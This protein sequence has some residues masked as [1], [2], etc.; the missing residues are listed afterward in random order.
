MSTKTVESKPIALREREAADAIGVAV[1]TLRN[2]RYMTPIKG[3]RPSRIGR[4]V[5]Y[6]VAEIERYL[7]EH[8]AR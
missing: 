8:M 5:V 7:D 4:T 6:P 1:K 3:P 2:W